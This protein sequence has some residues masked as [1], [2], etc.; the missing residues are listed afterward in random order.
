MK[1]LQFFSCSYCIQPTI[2]EEFIIIIIILG[3]SN[4]TN[5]MGHIF[6]I[7]TKVVATPFFLEREKTSVYEKIR[8]YCSLNQ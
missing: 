7:H 4:E 3:I 2:N 8:S 5:N 6:S 1:I